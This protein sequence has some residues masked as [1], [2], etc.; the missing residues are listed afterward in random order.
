MKYLDSLTNLISGLGTSKDKTIA[1]TYASR[2]I[3]DGQLDNAYRG[4]W[5]A[6]KVI[7]IPAEDATREW[8]YWQA[9]KDQI[10]LLDAEEKRLKLNQVVLTALKKARLKGGAA[11]VIG[12]KNTSVDQWAKELKPES[13]KQGDLAYLHAVGRD[14]I[15]AGP[16]NRD[17]LSPY[18]DEPE[19]YEV[20]SDSDNG[21]VRIHPSRVVRFLGVKI[22]TRALSLNGWGDSVLQRLDDAIKNAGLAQA[23]IASMMQESSVDVIRIPQFMHS[24]GTKAYESKILARFQLAATG[25]SINRSLM[26]D[27]DE[28]WTKMS[29]NFSNLSDLL[30][31]YLNIA[32]SASDIPAT[33][34]L[35]QSPGGLNATGDS[36]IRNYYDNVGSKQRN[37]ITPALSRLDEVLIYSALGS[38]P[39]EIHYNWKPLWQMT[40]SEKADNM[41]KKSQAIMNYANSGL[42]NTD[43]LSS[44]AS[45]ML[46]EDG[47]LPGL[48]NALEEAEES[49]S[50]E[51]PLN[52][53]DDDVQEQFNKLKNGEQPEDV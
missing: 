7:D 37:E 41:L 22:L 46:I 42:I 4:D 32:A 49:E 38:R 52:E 50:I 25:K 19:Y 12:I 14:E 28:E 15:T 45:N 21:L 39:A 1:T 10:T 23:E 24:I 9:D 51:E 18:Y 40:E 17:L 53:S 33:R 11:I 26:L 6:A 29:Q 8:R 35:G 44:A 5:I 3:D 16:V 13:V 20:N 48:E 47:V 27:K 30:K 34:F 31:D 43:A 36:D 2:F